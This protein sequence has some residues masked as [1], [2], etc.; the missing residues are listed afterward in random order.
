LPIGDAVGHALAG[1]K[2]TGFSI[3]EQSAIRREE[4]LEVLLIKVDFRTREGAKKQWQQTALTD[5]MENHA[6]V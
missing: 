3:V 5:V 2:N 4:P 1:W 6:C